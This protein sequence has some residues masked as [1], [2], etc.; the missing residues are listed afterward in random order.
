MSAVSVS[1]VTLSYDNLTVAEH[2]SF[3][4]EFGDYVCIVG[5]NGTGKSTLLKTIVGIHQPKSGHILFDC[6]IR[7]GDIGYLPQQTVVRDDFPA[8]VGEIVLSGCLGLLGK[9][10]FFG[11]EERRIADKNMD[12][13]GISD[14][15][16]TSFRELSGGQRQRVLLAKALCCARKILVLD[17]PVTGLD[18]LVTAD[19]YSIL[20]LINGEG[21]TIIMVS[22]E[23][24]EAVKQAS[25]ILHLKHG[26]EFY[27]K[28]EDY[29]KSSV[30]KLFTG[31][32]SDA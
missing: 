10:P 4:V 20:R 15:K 26:V 7:N 32:G 1:D 11:A 9:R 23:I 25:K 31:G 13:L 19:M 17:E 16:K 22:H 30:G 6:D 24:G 8:S 27:G 29:L 21:V 14:L 18:P 2:V 3:D 12:L 28:T 5:E